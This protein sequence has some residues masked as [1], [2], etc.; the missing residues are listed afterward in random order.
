MV[1]ENGILQEQLQEGQEQ[2]QQQ[3]VVDAEQA[4]KEERELEEY[5]MAQ[6][7]LN[8]DSFL[9]MEDIEQQ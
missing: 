8:I 6:F 3:Q 9:Y 4:A 2:Q 7:N 5:L 1:D